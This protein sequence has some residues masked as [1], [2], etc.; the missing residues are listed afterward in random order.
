MGWLPLRGRV[1]VAAQPAKSGGDVSRQPL[2]FATRTA[3]DW[4]RDPRQPDLEVR[5]SWLQR[6]APE[7]SRVQ[8]PAAPRGPTSHAG[9][10]FEP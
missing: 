3:H 2:P 5:C 6:I 1:D 7:F 8:V 4:D 10:W 9:P